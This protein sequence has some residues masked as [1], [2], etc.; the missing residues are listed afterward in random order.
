VGGEQFSTER[1]VGGRSYTSWYEPLRDETGA[2]A[3][4]VALSLDVTDRVRTEAERLWLQAEVIRVQES[5]LRELS[6][7]LIPISDTTVVMPLSGALDSRRAQGVLETL[8]E[9]VAARH[10]RVDSP[11][12]QL[13]LAAL[14]DGPLWAG[15][16]QAIG[17]IRPVP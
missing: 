7:P 15:E 4:T 10:A 17:R 5:A 14:R 1:A 3:G 2:L 9:G 16:Q 6:T 11:Q 13:R 12:N 8:L